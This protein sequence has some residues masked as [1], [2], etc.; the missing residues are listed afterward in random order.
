MESRIIKQH[1]RSVAQDT[2]THSRGALVQLS[3]ERR[4]CLQTFTYVAPCRGLGVVKVTSEGRQCN[5][6]KNERRKKAGGRALPFQKDGDGIKF[7]DKTH[8]RGKL[9]AMLFTKEY[10]SSV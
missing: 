4:E 2:A 10:H 9:S 5:R 8:E 1:R 6:L 3:F 7:S